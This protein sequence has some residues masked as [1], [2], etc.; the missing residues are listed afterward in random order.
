MNCPKCRHELSRFSPQP[1]FELDL[2]TNCKG[3]WFDRGELAAFASLSQDIPALREVWHDARV[4]QCPCPR[5]QTPLEELHYQS[6]SILL[7]DR[8][9]LCGGIWL[10]E[11]ELSS[12]SALSNTSERLRGVLQQ[13]QSHR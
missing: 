5:C 3:I 13:L 12:V 2:C 1:S 8:C 6:D 11:G 4:T 10:D 7:V 9:P